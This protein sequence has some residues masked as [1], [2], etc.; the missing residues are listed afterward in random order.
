M[1]KT[2]AIKVGIGIAIGAVLGYIYYHFFGCS[3]G[4][5]ISSN[6]LTSVGFG[7]VFGAV[8]MYPSK[9]KRQE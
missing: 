5:A 3:S 4:C 9:P 2:I 1:S 7:A 8:I 6:W